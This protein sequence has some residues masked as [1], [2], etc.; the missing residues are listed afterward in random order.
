MKTRIIAAAAAALVLGVGALVGGADARRPGGGISDGFIEELRIT[1][2]AQFQ[3]NRRMVDQ[4]E[5][6]AQALPLIRAAAAER[7]ACGD[8]GCEGR[9]FAQL[10]EDL[11]RLGAFAD[12]DAFRYETLE[13]YGDALR[14]GRADRAAA[15][16]RGMI[17]AAAAGSSNRA[18]TLALS[19]L[20]ALA[21][22]RGPGA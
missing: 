13:A 18:Q 17:S 21:A 20:D 4:I 2:A 14:R 1:I 6:D 19:R 16:V 8:R 11:G 15:Q 22:G 3:L 12:N 9:V 10:G 7:A 5:A